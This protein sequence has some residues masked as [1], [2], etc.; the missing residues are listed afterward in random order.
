MQSLTLDSIV[1]RAGTS[2]RRRQ[3]RLRDMVRHERQTVAMQFAAALHHSSDVGSNVTAPHGDRRRQAQGRAPGVLKEPEVQG[4][5]PHVQR[6]VHGSLWIVPRSQAKKKD[7]GFFPVVSSS[8]SCLLP[9][10][11]C[12]VPGPP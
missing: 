7:E 4:Q 2:V 11:G 12:V 9:V 10:K 1:A 6:M 3:R 8:T 5:G